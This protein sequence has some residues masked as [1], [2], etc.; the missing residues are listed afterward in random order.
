M[1]LLR[2][3][4]IFAAFA[5]VVA[6]PGAQATHV[7]EP[8]APIEGLRLL[9][10]NYGSQTIAPCDGSAFAFGNAR[11]QPFVDATSAPS[12][13]FK[14]RIFVARVENPGTNQER[15]LRE[16]EVEWLHSNV[17]PHPNNVNDWQIVNDVHSAVYR[18]GDKPGM[19]QVLVSVQGGVSGNFFEETCRFT[20]GT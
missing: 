1:R 18:M 11:I 14:A 8:T 15:L 5:L 16:W 4:G 2:R 6:V 9:V 20:V 10:K 3:L 19:W 12:E 13:H 17:E 7:S